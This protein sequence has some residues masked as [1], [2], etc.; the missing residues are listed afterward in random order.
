M[1]LAFS[2]LPLL[3]MQG[4]VGPAV[5]NALYVGPAGLICP[6]LRWGDN[7][8]ALCQWETTVSRFWGMGKGR[9]PRD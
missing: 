5:A 2:L 1:L 3:C 7:P 8:Q 4:E 6:A 9:V